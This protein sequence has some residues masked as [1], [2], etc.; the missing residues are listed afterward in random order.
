LRAARSG[1]PS[2]LVVDRAVNGEDGLSIIEILRLEGNFTPILVVGP[3]SSVDER[4]NGLKAGADD[5]LVKPFDARE[6]A[7]RVEAVLRRTSDPRTR[8]EFG[9]LEMDLVERN[10]RCAGRSVDLEFKLLEYMMRR[11]GQAVS[12]AKLLED[13]WNSKFDARSNVVDVHIG[14]LRRKLDPIGERQYIVS[15]QAIGFK[16]K[17][18]A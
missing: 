14:N 11:P 16:L 10:V 2:V 1:W 7:A 9:D 13:V 3:P 17:V 5:C 4:I 6:L 15:V 18:E 8:L 12:R